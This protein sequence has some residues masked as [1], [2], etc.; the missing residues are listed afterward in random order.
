[1][2][3]NECVNEAGQYTTHNTIADRTDA[4]RCALVPC[5][6]LEFD[7]KPGPQLAVRVQAHNNFSSPAQAHKLEFRPMPGP[8]H[9]CLAQARPI[10]AGQRWVSKPAAR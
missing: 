3:N 6:G 5:A 1:M 7:P 2:F 10:P 8:D 9:E 4:Y